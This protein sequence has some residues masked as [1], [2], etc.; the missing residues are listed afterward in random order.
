MVLE[1]AVAD[2]CDAIVSHNVRDF[3]GIEEF[4]LEVWTPQ[5]LLNQV[6]LS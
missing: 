5:V 4:G 6:T 2:A 1:L 3:A